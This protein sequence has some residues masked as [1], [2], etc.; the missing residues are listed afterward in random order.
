MNSNRIEKTRGSFW[1]V[2]IRAGPRT[3]HKSL[4]TPN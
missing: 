3:S 2:V 1:K 4:E